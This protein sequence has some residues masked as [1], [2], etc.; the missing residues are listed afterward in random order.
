ME[1]LNGDI[2][3]TTEQTWSKRIMRRPANNAVVSQVVD[4]NGFCQG[5][6]PGAIASEAQSTLSSFQLLV[7]EKRHG[8]TKGVRQSRCLR[9]RRLDQGHGRRYR[10]DRP[11]GCHRWRRC[12]MTG[13]ASGERHH[14]RWR[15]VV[16]DDK[17]RFLIRTLNLATA[18]K[19][20]EHRGPSGIIA[21]AHDLGAGEP[22]GPTSGAS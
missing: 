22:T 5:H 18:V 19:H 16:P 4:Y 17:L 1:R 7:E 9:C 3:A 2:P 6:A 20:V 13:H 8:G 12:R 14:R 15:Y 21:F 11:A 10:L